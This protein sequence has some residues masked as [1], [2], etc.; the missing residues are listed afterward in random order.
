[1][2]FLRCV[3]YSVNADHRMHQVNEGDDEKSLRHSLLTVL[4]AGLEPTIPIWVPYTFQQV[5]LVYC[6]P[7]L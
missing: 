2:I 4:R 6:T 5:L 3:F 7:L 1:M